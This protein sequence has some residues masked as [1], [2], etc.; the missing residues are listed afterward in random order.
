MLLDQNPQLQIG[1]NRPKTLVISIAVH[2]VLILLIAFNP[3]WFDSPNRRTIRIAGEDFDL[4]K[5]QIQPL[6]LPPRVAQMAPPPQAVPVPV[7]QV[8]QPPVAAPPPPP[9]PPPPQPTPQP[10]ERVIRPDDLLV[11]GARPDGSP[12][13]SRGNTPDPAR[14]GGQQAARDAQI[15]EAQEALDAMEAQQARQA[16]RNRGGND[17]IPPLN[18][19]PNALRA[20]TPSLL[21]SAGKIVDAN[22]AR[23]GQAGRTGIV[24]SDNNGTFST[25]P[26]ILSDNPKGID[27]G[28]YLNQL[29]T[30]LRANWYSVMPE[31]ARLGQKGRV[32]IVFTVTKSGIVK[33]IQVVN[34]SGYS[35]LDLAAQSAI[36]LSNPFQ[37][38]PAEYETDLKL[39]IAFLYNL[40]P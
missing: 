15:R 31:I 8:V 39:R 40:N 32:D 12:R 10:P 27:F 24:R 26:Q 28:P 19:N 25:D 18:T 13:A 33:D 30:K 38:L 11:E 34:N 36:H 17:R 9:P 14:N 1:A 22:M 4:A 3:D 21:A 23:A 6:Y 2:V 37:H 5:L 20:P 16:Q 35:P 7:P 29:L